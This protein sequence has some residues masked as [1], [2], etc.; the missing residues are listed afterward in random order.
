[1]QRMLEAVESSAHAPAR[2]EGR[3][4]DPATPLSAVASPPLL[5]KGSSAGRQIANKA[6]C[7]SRLSPNLTW[8]QESPG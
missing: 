5:N 1:M 6:I 7:C 2:S 4:Q 3:G 8:F